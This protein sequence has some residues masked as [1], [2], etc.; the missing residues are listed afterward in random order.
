LIPSINS[1]GGMMGK[2]TEL[3]DDLLARPL[4]PREI[5]ERREAAQP[6]HHLVAT[7]DGELVEPAPTPTQVPRVVRQAPQQTWD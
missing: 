1:K 3:T 6:R 5:Q 4:S 7:L 2:A